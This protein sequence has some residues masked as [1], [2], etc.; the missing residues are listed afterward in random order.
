MNLLFEI[1]CWELIEAMFAQKILLEHNQILRS[2][3]NSDTQVESGIGNAVTL[4]VFL[5][6][7]SIQKIKPNTM[8]QL[9]KE[10]VKEN[11]PSHKFFEEE[12]VLSAQQLVDLMLVTSNPAVALAICQVVREQT[13]KKMSA[14]YRELPWI[15]KLEGALANQTGRIRSSV[16]QRY[17]I[18]MLRCLGVAFSQLKLSY[19]DLMHQTD[20]VQSGKYFYN[21]TMLVKNGELTGGYF[22][23]PNNGDAIAFDHTNMYVILGAE[24]GYQRDIVLSKLVEDV[25][26][27]SDSQLSAYAIDELNLKSNQPVISFWGDVYP[28]EFYSKRRLKRQQWDPLSDEGYDYTFLGMKS[29]LQKSSLNVFN[30][31]SV[32]V[33][34]F[35]S[36]KLLNSKTFVLGSEPRKTLSAF[37]KANLGLAL[38]ANNHGGDYGEN[39]FEQSSK[40]LEEAKIP[41]IGVGQDI[42]KAT[43]PVRING[44]GVK[45]SLFNAYW[46]NKRYYRDYGFYSLFGKMGVSPLG[47]ELLH[48]IARERLQNPDRLIVV[49]PHWGTDFQ[50]VAERQKQLAMKMIIA[51]ADIIIGHGA[52]ALQDIELISGHPVFYGLGNAFFN[53]EGE[54]KK[55]PHS[56]PFGG[57][58]EISASAG[59]MLLTVRFMNAENHETKFQPRAVTENEFS[60]LILGLKSNGSQLDNWKIDN[61]TLQYVYQKNR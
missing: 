16:K 32:L 52:H 20:C 48:K 23:G 19:R 17:D 47:E 35:E 40:Y 31:E 41:H 2:I 59:G 57:F 30:L 18:K 5:N 4:Y 21:S 54:F 27:V 1:R 28:G 56:L 50:P 11:D 60:K 43:N 3:G 8:T 42:D 51:G 6:L 34:D 13:H 44:Q 15:N 29:F 55:Y 49:S 53:S 33:D 10:F 46:Y 39:G 24:N 38:M 14:H 45:I 7:M 36:S 22:F 37:K 26:E 9:S 12:E 25:N 58:V 61:Q